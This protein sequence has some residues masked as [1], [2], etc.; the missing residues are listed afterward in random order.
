MHFLY[1]SPP[2]PGRELASSP[3]TLPPHTIERVNKLNT[4]L[5]TEFNAMEETSNR[6]RK[7]VQRCMDSSALIAQHLALRARI[8][9]GP[10]RKNE[11]K[12]LQKPEIDS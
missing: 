7:H 11:A 2:F 6:F 10:H 8:K 9:Q 12:S 3:V 4:K 5:L 1:T